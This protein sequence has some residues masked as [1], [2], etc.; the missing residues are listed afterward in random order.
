MLEINYS[1]FR[2]EA[3][4]SLLNVIEQNNIILLPLPITGSVIFW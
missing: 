4:T 1:H 3:F 2:F